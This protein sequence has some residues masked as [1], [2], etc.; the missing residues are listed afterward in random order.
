MDKHLWELFRARNPPDSPKKWSFFAVFLFFIRWRLDTEGGQC[1]YSPTMVTATRSKA[2]KTSPAAPARGSARKKPARTYNSALKYLFSHTDYERMLRVRYNTD[3]FSLERMSL[4]LQKL[5]NPHKRLRTV[6]IAGTKGKGSTATMLAEMLQACGYRVGL[7][8]SPHISDLRERIRVNGQMITQAGLT[9]LICAAERHIK[10]MSDD[11]PTF[12][13]IF[14]ALAFRHFANEKVDIA[15]IE[16]GLGGRLDSTNVLTPAVVGLTSISLDHMHQLG[17]SV[18]KI[19]AEK[20]GVLKSN[21]PAVSVPQTPEAKEVLQRAARETNANLMFTGEDIDFS[22][23]VESSRRQGCHTRICVTTP[24]SRFEH[25]TVPLQGEHQALNCG[26]ALAL[27]DQ[28]KLQ[29]MKIDDEQAMAGLAGVYVPGR[30][31]MLRDDP[32]ILVDG[33]H[34]AASIEALIRAIGQNIPYDS[35]VMVF[36]CASDKD[37]PGM[38]AQIAKGAD[39]VVFTKAQDSHRAMEARELAD[40]YEEHSGRVAQIAENMCEAINVASSAV[41]REDIICICGSFYLVGEAKKLL[42][43]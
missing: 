42:A 36:G 40:I 5:R 16:C 27:L 18:S 11:R 22:Y 15:V 17:N 32:R 8:T 6:H 14:T 39:K 26:L 28:L 33:A 20:A 34:N 9:R 4:L 31:E 21:V 38:I 35:M 13:E 25:L 1:V 30:M 3:T 43:N 12:F 29:G 37:I 41:T 7:Y 23:R 24:R 2:Q 19:A 10:K